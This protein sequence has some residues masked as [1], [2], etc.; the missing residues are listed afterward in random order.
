MR[1]DHN[2]QM[3]CTS[4]HDPHNNEFGKFL[5]QDNRASALCIECHNMTAWTLS[6]HRNSSKT[7]NDS[8]VVL[9]F[10][11]YRLLYNGAATSLGPGVKVL[12][13][14]PNV[15]IRNGL[16]STFYSAV[17]TYS[18]G[19]IVEDMRLYASA[20]AIEIMSGAEGAIVRRNYIR[21]AGQA[22]VVIGNSARIVDNDIYG[23]DTSTNDGDKN[24]ADNVFVVG[25]RFGRLDQAIDYTPGYSGK[26][27]DNLTAN[28]TTPYTGGTSAGNNN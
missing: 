4:C 17:H 2:N 24:W 19:T 26:Y 1:L 8:G 21:N 14:N 15:V 25:N 16:I 9:D 28:V 22:V 7:W 23:L 18:F 10:N 20:Y 12:A 3:Q 5:V 6:A 13:D 11:G 27:R